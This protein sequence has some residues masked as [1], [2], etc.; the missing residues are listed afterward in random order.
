MNQDI[1]KYLDNIDFDDF[2]IKYN[3]F[4]VILAGGGFKG[5]YHLGLYK[6]LK[7]L[8]KKNKIKIRYIVGTSTGAI[9]AI[10][11]VCNLDFNRWVDTFYKIKEN[12]HKSDLHKTVIEIM[13]DE[14]PENAYQLCTNRIKI[15][16]SKLTMFG[17]VE[18][19]FDKF[20][21]NDHLLQVLS[22]SIKI[23]YLTSKSIFGEKINSYYY[24][25]GF[26]TRIAPIIFNSDLP[27]LFVKTYATN[28]SNSLSLKPVD[29]HI[30]LLSLRGA[31]ESK[32]FFKYEKKN[33]ILKWI[34]PKY[35]RK[36]SF[37]KKYIHI[38][39]PCIFYFSSVFRA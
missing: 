28:Y 31:Y 13:K 33:K 16:T 26:F 30:E 23:P 25:D 5:Y 29:S 24:Y 18:E 14:L 39:V 8:E 12:M 17:F 37:Y 19:I 15:T 20:D 36:I 38:I 35:K 10:I 4:D 27:Q 21:S 22:A 2:E 1:I 3:Y 11:Y 9:S 6:I 32:K 34:E 7:H